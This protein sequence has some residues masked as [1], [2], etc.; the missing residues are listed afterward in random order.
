MKND[1]E[2][3]KIENQKKGKNENQKRKVIG[4]E[5]M[6]KRKETIKHQRKE[7]RPV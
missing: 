7:E 5:R 2:R 4:K 6:E 1:C 3:K